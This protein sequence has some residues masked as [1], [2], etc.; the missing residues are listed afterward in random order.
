MRHPVTPRWTRRL[1]LSIALG[2]VVACEDS[3]V[4]IPVPTMADIAGSYTATS[5]TA[6][7]FDVLAEGGSL[8]LVL[9]SE[10]SVSGAMFVPA[11]VGGPLQAD[12]AGTYTLAEN[13]ITISQ[14]AD[15][16]V[17]DAAWT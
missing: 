8:D 15:T 1:L 14:E 7:Q 3:P 16:F 11:A 13:S 10:G 5:F 6:G 12:M 9:G 17:R 2:A 4:E